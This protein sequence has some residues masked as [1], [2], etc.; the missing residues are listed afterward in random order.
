MGAC[1]DKRSAAREQG[2]GSG[3]VRA[4]LQER[5]DA[6]E[7][8]GRDGRSGWLFTGSGWGHGVG[9]CQIGSVNLAGRGATYR[10]I[11]HHYYTGVEAARVVGATDR[12]AFPGTIPP[13]SRPEAART[14]SDVR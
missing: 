12:F 9:L 4:E 13:E 14:P 8:R 1:V 7:A 2:A 6:E 3:L 5:R 11:L 10:E